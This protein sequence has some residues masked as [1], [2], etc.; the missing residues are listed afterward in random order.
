M[1][2]DVSKHHYCVQKGMENHIRVIWTHKLFTHDFSAIQ[3][4][5]MDVN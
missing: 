3:N 1:R 2:S 5:K 4:N